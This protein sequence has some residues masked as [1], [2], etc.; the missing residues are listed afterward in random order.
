[1]TLYLH[2]SEPIG[3]EFVDSHGHRL[4]ALACLLYSIH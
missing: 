3:T 1:M 2:H 4:R